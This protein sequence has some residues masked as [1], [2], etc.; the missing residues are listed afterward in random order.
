MEASSPWPAG[1]LTCP[2]PRRDS[3]A[4]YGVHT[5]SM[6][7]CP[8]WLWKISEDMLR[9]VEGQREKK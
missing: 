2:P 8:Y 7:I 4:R 9:T 3:H 6:L 5:Y 1:G